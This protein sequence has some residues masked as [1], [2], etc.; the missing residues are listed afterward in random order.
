MLVVGRAGR[1]WRAKKRRKQPETSSG[2]GF[3]GIGHGRRMATPAGLARGC[4]SRRGLG[5]NSVLSAQLAGPQRAAPL[6]PRQ[7]LRST[8]GA[9]LPRARLCQPGRSVWAA[10]GLSELGLL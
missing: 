4:G 10:Q 1:P 3:G 8:Q 5:G 2:T 9:A 7:G 6:D